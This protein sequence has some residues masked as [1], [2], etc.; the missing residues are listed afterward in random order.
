MKNILFKFTIIY[1]SILSLCIFLL[2]LSFSFDGNVNRNAY[3]GIKYIE[4]NNKYPKL[5]QDYLPV[6]WKYLIGSWS[7]YLQ[8]D[9]PT[10]G[11]MLRATIKPNED[12]LNTVMIPSYARY[13]HGY[14]IIIRPLLNFIDYI[15]I[16]YLGIIFHCIGLFYVYKYTAKIS[17]FLARGLFLSFILY[18]F[19]TLWQSLP[20]YFV[21]FITYV[22]IIILTECKKEYYK[23]IFF[24]NGMLVAFF[25]FLTAPLIA[26]GI[27]LLIVYA[28]NKGISVQK[29]ILF[30]FIWGIRYASCWLAKPLIAS[31]I[32]NKNLFLDFMQQAALRIDGGKSYYFQDWPIKL[33]A[34]YLNGRILI[35]LLPIIF[36]FRKE[37][38]W[39][40]DIAIPLLLIAAMP[41][42]WVCILANHSALHFWFTSRIVIIT[43]FA[44]FVYIYMLRESSHVH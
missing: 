38:Y 32:L 1:I 5:F 22:S 17:I 19:I 27:P 37:I 29:I 36:Y 39:R 34:C 9:R 44:F 11:A 25:D 43:F 24:I 33:V 6:S 14:I 4:N 40:A 26:L 16:K 8:A 21:Y 7:D 41:C 20:F 28:R 31:F 35:W 10:E 2:V 30:S 15:H 23:Y 13:W 12:I 3:D 18:G 42:I